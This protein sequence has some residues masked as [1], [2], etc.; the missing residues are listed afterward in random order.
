MLRLTLGALALSAAALAQQTFEVASVKPSAPSTAPNPMVAQAMAKSQD[1]IYDSR[2]LGW[3]PIEK[4]RLTMKNRS[5]AGLIASACRVRQR[6]VSGPAWLA[7]D[8]YEIEAT[9]PADTPKEAVNDMLRALLEERFGLK[10]HREDRE[11]AG[12]ALVETKGG[13]KLV[14]AAAKSEEPAAPMSDEDRRAQREKMQADMQKRMEAMRKQAAA[15]GGP[16]SGPGGG[17]STNSWRSP[18][19]TLDQVAGWL[20]P[21]LEKPVVDATGIQG[22]YDFDI[23]VQRF[24]DDTQEYA[25]A[26]ALAKFGL[27]LEARK[28]SVSTVVVDQVERKPKEN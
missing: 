18:E 9:F 6:D 1:R 26:Q 27:K 21:Q 12:Y 16:G 2:P 22:K 7:E 5:L 10:V 23:Q 24:G 3:L 8:R 4:T 13:A 25:I 11:L 15:N 14:P 19:A 20:A 17:F 28:V